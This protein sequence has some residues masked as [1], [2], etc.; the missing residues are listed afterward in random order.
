MYSSELTLSGRKEKQ[1]ITLR[2]SVWLILLINHVISQDSG[3]RHCFLL[4]WG[5]FAALSFE[6]THLKIELKAD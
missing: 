2:N 1:K 3:K 4:Q 6:V 5:H